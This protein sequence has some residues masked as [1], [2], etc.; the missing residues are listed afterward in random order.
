[1][2]VAFR[3]S[4]SRAVIRIRVF[5]N[6]RARGSFFF[7]F[8]SF[9]TEMFDITSSRFQLQR[10]RTNANIQGRVVFTAIPGVV[11]SRCIH[12]YT[13]IRSVQKILFRVGR[14]AR[15]RNPETSQR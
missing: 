4:L 15:N 5:H 1:M 10:I 8:L 6:K 7:F 2:V 14:V 3:F 11:S 13:Y 9:Q 12:T